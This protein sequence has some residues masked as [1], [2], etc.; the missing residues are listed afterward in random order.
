LHGAVVFRGVRLKAAVHDVVETIADVDN[1]GLG[2]DLP[3]IL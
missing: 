3:D 2:V 1:E